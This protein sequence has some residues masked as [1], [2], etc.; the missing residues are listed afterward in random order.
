MT[1]VAEQRATR[2]VFT[3]DPYTGHIPQLDLPH[4]VKLDDRWKLVDRIVTPPG[5]TPHSCPSCGTVIQRPTK[6]LVA[7]VY[8]I[9]HWSGNPVC[10][11]PHPT[12]VPADWRLSEQTQSS[13]SVY[14][15]CDA[16]KREF[17]KEDPA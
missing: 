16:H 11:F 12:P 1:F 6:G 8:E 9:Q 14:Y 13:R 2:V 10:G 15:A 17:L 3:N 5:T 7:E 4:L